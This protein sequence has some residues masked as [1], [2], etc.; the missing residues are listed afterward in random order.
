[1]RVVNT[2]AKSHLA[3]TPEKYL[4]EAERANMNMYL[5]ACLQQ[6]PHFYP[7]V[8]SINGLL[9]VE[10]TDT[11]KMIASCFETK[12][13]QPYS[14]TCGYVK[15]RISITLVPATHRCIRG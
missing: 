4:H 11:L 5:E 10:A 9:G 3:K 2:D 14:R 6:H 13:Q 8:A 7:F 15:S 12:W 1:M